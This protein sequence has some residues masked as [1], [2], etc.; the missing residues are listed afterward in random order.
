[1]DFLAPIIDLLKKLVTGFLNIGASNPTTEPT[2]DVVVSIQ[3]ISVQLCGFLPMAESVI[4]LLSATY[5]GIA[6]P[7]SVAAQVARS[8]C[9][10]A[11][12]EKPTFMAADATGTWQQSATVTVNGVPVTGTWVNK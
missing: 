8:I 4:A 11:S 1:M 2:P 12:A 5:P 9:Q 10:A 7:L 3:S 6:A